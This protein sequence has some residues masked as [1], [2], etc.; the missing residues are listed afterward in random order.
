MNDWPKVK[1]RRNCFLRDQALFASQ[2]IRAGE[3]ICN[4]AGKTLTN[5]E[6]DMLL[7]STTDP[8]KRQQIT[9]YALGGDSYTIVSHDEAVVDSAV[10]LHSFGRRANHSSLHPNMK[11]PQWVNLAPKGCKEDYHPLLQVYLVVT[12]MIKFF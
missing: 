7:S 5:R 3:W 2:P 8:V 6:Y 9:S 10:L 11:A 12:E 1:I 4:Y